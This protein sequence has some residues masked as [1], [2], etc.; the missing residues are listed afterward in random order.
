MS[1]HEGSASPSALP[2]RGA[3]AYVLELC[4]IG[5]V[6]FLLAKFGLALASINPSATPI[7]PPSGFALAAFLLRGYRIWPA[8]LVGAFVVNAT[9]AGSIATS[10]VIGCGNALEGLVGAYLINRWSGGRDT[11]ASPAGVARFALIS[12]LPTELSA[13]IGVVS[14]ALAGFVDWSSFG[15]IWLTWWLGDL[16]GALVITPVITLWAVSSRQSL[17]SWELAESIAVFACACAIGV[18]AFS[19]LI[20][21]THQAPLGFLAVVPLMWSALRRG[22]RDTATVALI[23]SC[24]AVWDTLA[25][26]GP[27][28][29]GDL[30]ESFLLL[31]MF[32]I[33]IAIPS[34]ALS[35]DVAMRKRTEEELR[36]TQDE[37]NQRVDRRTSALTAT[38]LA[39]R[40][41]VDRR[42]HAEAELDQQRRYLVEAQRLAN[43]GSWIRDLDSGKVTWSAQLFDIYG[44]RPDQF[45]GTFDAVL[46]HVHPDDRERVAAEARNA[47]ETGQRFQTEMRIIRPG[48]E[49][50]HLQNCIEMIK[51]ENDRIVR[52]LG[53]SQDVSERRA[54]ETALERTR[55]QLAQLQKMEAIGQ[56]TGGIAHDFNNLLMIV[57]G[58]AE[59]LRR[60]LSEPKALAGLDA[61]QGAARR[62]ESL[63][64]QLL[65]FSRRQPL[66]P[67][68]VDLRARVEAVRAMLAGSLLDSVSLVVDI[69]P[70]VWPVEVDIAEFELAL[71]NIAVNAR[72]AMPQGGTFTLS[73]RNVVAQAARPAG[74]PDGDH[75]ELALSDT[76]VGI[77]PDTIKRI[78]DPFFTTKAVGK[79]S[80]L[81]LSQVYGFAHQSGGTVSVTS[82]VG[83]G[84]TVTLR[85]PR[86][87]AAVPAAREP[88][89]LADAGHGEG[90]ILVVEDNPEVGE[91]TATL[92]EQIGYRVLRAENAAQ[93]LA[94]LQDGSKVDL[95]FSDIVMPNGMNGIHLAQEVS[96]LYP[97]LAVLLTTGYSDVA[98]AA[99]TRFSILR[100]PFEVTALER[101][102]SKAL[103]RVGVPAGRE[104]GRGS[105]Q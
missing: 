26:F 5:V 64:R 14:L 72:D 9:T 32:M 11:Y 41:E 28:S 65:T 38:N 78:F 105:A 95:L 66:D 40:E 58:H 22:Q 12:F 31:L 30:N 25:G 70:E 7:W 67:V 29:Q 3:A 55:E 89:T 80:G 96:K 92:L 4:L 44:L 82:E 2:I 68:P 21:Q 1:T 51:D 8:I 75:V 34:L 45:G 102:V 61:I 103:A 63:T 59:L 43:L 76:G 53:I 104:A 77:A 13:T 27:F 88:A 100:K 81:G 91:V 15:S 97:T 57:T 73:A 52:M 69:P 10:I 79:G 20:E 39:L 87:H 48:G 83:R 16:A 49:V 6:Y 93:A 36:R 99:E 54:A 42:K 47:L 101:A 85:F 98:A 56:L 33:S 17:Q 71:V 35:A 37:L 19:P 23:F 90:T 86:T 46:E 50:R 62:G 84:T 60:R 24:F 74:Q 94:C 18:I